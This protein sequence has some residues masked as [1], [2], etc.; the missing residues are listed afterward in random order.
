[1]VRAIALD[2]SAVSLTDEYSL[3]SAPPEYRDDNTSI[4]R[5]STVIVRRLPPSKPGRG[6]AQHY[7][8]DLQAGDAGGSGR[9]SGAAAGRDPH[10]NRQQQQ[11]GGS[12]SY[13]GP[14]SIRFDERD[15]GASSS[16]TPAP[17]PVMPA[18]IS[19]QNGDE[20]SGIAAMFQATTEQWDATQEQMSHATYRAR[21]GGP[22]RGGPPGR[23]FTPRGDQQRPQS[24]P[25]SDRP[26]PLGYNCFRCGQKGHW[27]QDCPTN[28]DPE[29]DNKPRFKRTTGIPKSM[30]K[31][32]E[33]PTDEQRQQ[34]VMITADGTYVVAQ[35][36]NKTWENARHQV[37][38]LSR[39]DVFQSVPSDSSLAC[40]L[41]SKLLRSAVQTPCCSTRYC[42]ECV[43][44]HLLEH[45]FTCAECEKRIADLAKLER[46]EET[47]KRVD[48]YV[49]EAVE[50][51]ETEIK[52]REQREQEE[53]EAQKA[54]KE[55]AEAEERKKDAKT[56]NSSE[57]GE[58]DT[59]AGGDSNDQQGEVPSNIPQVMF[60]PQLVQQLV[61]TLSNPQL[62]PPMRMMLQT[63]LQAQQMAFM[64][65]QKQGG[66]QAQQQQQQQWGGMNGNRPQM[67][68]MNGMQG[69]GG[70]PMGGMNGMMG[71]GGAGMMGRMPYNQQHQQFNQNN[72]GGNFMMNGG[73]GGGNHFNN[74]G[75]G[76]L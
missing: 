46:D 44:N 9:F 21:G 24:H 12:A 14:M 1:M 40:P 63:Q 48:K 20:A 35:V 34:G 5:S 72:G 60:N 36:D 73:A 10:A 28:N 67:G 8:A 52:E 15:R 16:A 54:A 68:M 51:S 76:R 19:E 32:V 74:N 69:M 22:S 58:G 29:W 4:P 65:M 25:H 47:R 38:P 37:K 33:A 39:S 49:D 61:M 62:P 27:I 41:C 57:A 11:A 70:M 3:L 6:T 56:E 50:K 45:D 17:P 66:V 7:V 23:N 43:Q 26:P 18:T 2:I 31:T 75:G 42:E 59:D 71:G 53:E 30:L 64:R 13:R 55:A